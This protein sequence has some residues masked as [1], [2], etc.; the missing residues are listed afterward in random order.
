[1]HN[2]LAK[3]LDMVSVRCWVGEE[4]D[5]DDLAGLFAPTISGGW[6]SD[7]VSESESMM[8]VS[9]N[10]DLDA[11]L[12]LPEPLFVVTWPAAE[13]GLTVS[14]SVRWIDN[15]SLQVSVVVQ[16]GGPVT[17]NVFV[18]G[19]GGCGGGAVPTG[20]HFTIRDAI[21][22]I[23]CKPQALCSGGEYCCGELETIV[24]EPGE[25]RPV[26]IVVSDTP[27]PAITDAA[28]AGE[29]GLDVLDTLQQL[30]DA[31]QATLSE[32]TAPVARARMAAMSAATEAQ[33]DAAA[34]DTGY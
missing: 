34:G 11:G 28:A 2:I 7:V 21:A 3:N 19:C 22:N 27:R 6:C 15:A 10:I 12:R 25:S 33:L 4:H 18:G 1:M 5:T 24:L 14:R 31:Q 23:P 26:T 29:V 13:K 16:A 9:P 8:I 32:L 30:Q 20:T 17:D